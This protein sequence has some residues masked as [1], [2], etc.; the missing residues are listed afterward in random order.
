MTA[1]FALLIPVDLTAFSFTQS[2]FYN[3]QTTPPNCV[4][5]LPSA[6]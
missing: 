4:V 6:P 2:G 1:N 3:S 5:T